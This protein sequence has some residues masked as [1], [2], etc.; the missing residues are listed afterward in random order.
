MLRLLAVLGVLV[1]GGCAGGVQQSDQ[2]SGESEESAENAV[3]E[4]HSDRYA[5]YMKAARASNAMAHISQIRVMMEE[6]A[7]M[8]G[9]GPRFLSDLN[10]L[11][12]EVNVPREIHQVRLADEGKRIVALLEPEGADWISMRMEKLETFPYRNWVCELS[13]SL[14]AQ[15]LPQC[16][17]VEGLAFDAMAPSFDCEVARTKAEKTICRHDRLMDAD[18]RLDRAYRVVQ[19]MVAESERER[20]RQEQREWLQARD[21]ECEEGRQY[22]ACLEAAIRERTSNLFGELAE[23]ESRR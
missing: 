15:T 22:A 9:E 6:H 16:D 4:L 10:I 3:E 1:L 13:F 18:T 5:G 8:R 19:G 23:M 21:S 7:A 14:P 20:Y 12:P 17:V 2:G 11:Y